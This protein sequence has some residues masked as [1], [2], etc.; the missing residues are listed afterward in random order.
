ML[1]ALICRDK[2]G[3]LQTRLDTRE[4][5]LAHIRQSG[6]VA[7]AG[8]LIEDGEMRGSLVILDAETLEQAQ[9]WADADPYKAAGLFASVQLNE[10]KKVIG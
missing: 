9:A 6:I 5:H 7:M 1:Y 2:P 8:P 10:W 3:A 4:A